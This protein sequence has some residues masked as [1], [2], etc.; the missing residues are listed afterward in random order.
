MTY[1]QV[2][3][4]GESPRLNWVRGTVN[5][6]RFLF[7]I[8][9]THWSFKVGDPDDPVYSCAL[10]PGSTTSLEDDIH[11]FIIESARQYATRD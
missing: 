2:V 11:D 3:I 6:E 1:V 5:G 8:E 10:L 4:E 7:E 9:A